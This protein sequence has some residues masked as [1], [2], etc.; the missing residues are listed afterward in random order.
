MCSQLRAMMSRGPAASTVSL[1]G[2]QSIL[3]IPFPP[4]IVSF[5]VPPKIR[6]FPGEH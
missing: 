4:M 1:P 6:S 2:P 5:P 3:S